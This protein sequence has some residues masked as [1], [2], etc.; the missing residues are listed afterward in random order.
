VKVLL[1]MHAE[2]SSTPLVLCT[3]QRNSP[4][5]RDTV[6]GATETNGKSLS[7]SEA[8]VVVSTVVEEPSTPKQQLEPV[9]DEAASGAKSHPLALTEDM[10]AADELVQEL[11][12]TSSLGKRGELLFAAQ[13][14]AVLFVVWPPFR[15]AG[16][17]DLLATLALTAGLVFW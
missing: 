15:L 3:Q 1:R 16:L 9:V 10:F 12:D 14:L 13:S 5:N 11:K 8:D 4:K 2:S 17:F 7:S 6:L